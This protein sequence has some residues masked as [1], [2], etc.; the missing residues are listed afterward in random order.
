MA[1]GK[2]YGNFS[3]KF[4]TL[5]DIVIIVII[6]WAY[7]I[8]RQSQRPFGWLAGGRGKIVISQKAQMRRLPC[9]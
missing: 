8:L 7:N 3:Q 2:W 1:N 4:I 6:V 5:D 9:K